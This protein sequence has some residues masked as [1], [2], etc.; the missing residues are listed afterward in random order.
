MALAPRVGTYPSSSAMATACALARGANA[1]KT[2]N[3]NQKDCR[4]TST[5]D[6]DPGKKHKT[7][8]LKFQP[9]FTCDPTLAGNGICRRS[10]RN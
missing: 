4:G 10:T 7:S 5:V 8:P 3:G 1:P 6:E 9:D 2:A